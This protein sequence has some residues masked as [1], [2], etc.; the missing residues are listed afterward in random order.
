MGNLITLG[1]FATGLPVFLGILM[2][3]STISIILG[4]FLWNS[5][6]DDIGVPIMG[7]GLF[8]GIFLIGGALIIRYALQ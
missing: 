3:Y 8:I 6:R 5:R 1:L 2:A 7:S 4:F